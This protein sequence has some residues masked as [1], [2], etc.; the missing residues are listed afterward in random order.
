M[1]FSTAELK[2]S[3]FAFIYIILLDLKNQQV[4]YPLPAPIKSIIYKGDASSDAFFCAQTVPKLDL[5]VPALH[6]TQGQQ[7]TG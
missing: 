4:H 2:A 1:G 3:L 6:G 7:P 5:L